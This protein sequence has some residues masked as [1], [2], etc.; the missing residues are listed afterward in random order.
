MFEGKTHVVKPP[1][2]GVSD[3]APWEGKE[4]GT[5]PHYQHSEAVMVFGLEEDHTQWKEERVTKK[6]NK[7]LEAINMKTTGSGIQWTRKIYQ[8][9]KKK[10]WA[11]KISF[12]ITVCSV[13]EGKKLA[14][15]KYQN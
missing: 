4:P 5:T 10:R 13:K 7:I 8:G 1:G 12:K 14:Y 9:Q 11:V 3:W 15:N 2:Q 6:R